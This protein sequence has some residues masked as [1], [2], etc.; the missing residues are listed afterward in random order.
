[1]K[2]H[3][4]IRQILVLVLT[5]IILY[6]ILNTI[7]FGIITSSMVKKI[8]VQELQPEAK[9]ISGIIGKL[10]GEGVSNRK[11]EQQIKTIFF[12]RKN[13]IYLFDKNGKLIIKYQG[14]MALKFNI[15]E[16]L[17]IDT[18]FN[19]ILSENKTIL[20]QGNPVIFTRGPL[21]IVGEPIYSKG[22]VEGIILLTKDQAEL[23]ATFNSILRS[24]LLSAIGVLLLMLYP[25]YKMVRHI[26]NPL[27][28]MHDIAIKMAHGNLTLKADESSK[29]EIG[30]LGKSLNYLSC[31][32]S[33]SISDLKTERNSLQQIIDGLSEGIIAVDSTGS[34]TH[35]NPAI[36]H[37]FSTSVEKVRNRILPV[38]S[39]WEDFDVVLVNGYAITN[40]IEWNHNSFRVTIC[41]LRNEFNN[42]T[43][44]VGLF[45]D[46][47]A[48]EK[49]EQT[50]REY[51]ANVSHEL[52]TP[53]AAIRAL[54]ETLI[55]GLVTDEETQKR[56]YNNMLH[57]TMRL[58]RLINDLLVLSKLQTETIPV[59]NE[60]FVLGE[61]M[62][63]VAERFSV[64]ADEK[65]IKFSFEL[66]DEEL[67]VKSNMDLVEEV[68]IILL[69]NA[70]KYT[71]KGGSVSLY[72]HTEGT[73]VNIM[74]SDTGM[75][76]YEDDLPHIFE[77]FYKSDKAESAQG[78]GLGLAIAYEIIQ[79]LNQ[80]ISVSSVPD[81][82]STFTFSLPVK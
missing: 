82:G 57:E 48:F 70:I 19:K 32:L 45:Q 20:L 10:W 39:V 4:L 80:N 72:T 30:E 49:L 37:I 40:N 11:I 81:K 28:N 21:S 34:V 13:M 78:T 31:M 63:N 47:T 64:L 56:Y 27:K 33:K 73:H 25:I 16:T 61:I 67:I 51:V 76:I 44:A 9:E 52:R 15:N 23:G 53:V 65:E 60:E 14:D 8:Q 55:D 18:L 69:D 5:T 26:T 3:G 36:C 68:L 62:A 22:K 43:G 50:R 59:D 6:G 41:P 1:M 58:S 35:I 77:R 74:V 75:G 17:Q 71:H 29:G 38:R 24:V 54:L 7:I 46:I 66:P 42:I 2:K 12:F 79:K